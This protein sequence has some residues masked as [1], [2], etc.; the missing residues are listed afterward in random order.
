MLHIGHNAPACNFTPLKTGNIIASVLTKLDQI[1]QPSLEKH[2]RPG[3]RF[4]N[5]LGRWS[6]GPCDVRTWCNTKKRKKAE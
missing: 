5:S 4:T 3:A 6:K 1:A 2:A